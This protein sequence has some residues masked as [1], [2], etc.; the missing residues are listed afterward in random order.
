MSPEIQSYLIHIPL[1]IF[2]VLLGTSINFL[3]GRRKL[4]KSRIKSEIISSIWIST[5]LVLIL[6]NF[7]DWKPTAYYGIGSLAGFLNSKLIDYVGNDL[8]EVVLKKLLDNSPYNEGD[9][10]YTEGED[11]EDSQERH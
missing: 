10:D 4:T 3:R 6:D 5:V 1:F 8:L 2:F 9:G 7:F 11:P